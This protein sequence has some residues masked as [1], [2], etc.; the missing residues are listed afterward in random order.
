MQYF[1][2]QKNQNQICGTTD[3]PT[4][5]LAGFQVVK[6]VDDLP[7]EML[8]W[9]GFEIQIKPARP[10][11]LH[12]WQNNQWTLPEFTAPVTEN[13]TGLIDSLR[14]T[15]IWQKSFTAAGRTV[16]ANAAWTLL[17]GTLTSTQ[18]LPDLAFAIAELREAMRGIT[19][20]GDFTSEELDSLNQKLEANHFSL[21]LESSEV[22]G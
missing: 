18:S 3:D 21:R 16:R 6:G 7:A 4:L 19:A 12:F 10:S 17:Y 1:L 2:I 11:D 9:D 20:I 15:L 22:E 14:G 5:E 8:F 13:W